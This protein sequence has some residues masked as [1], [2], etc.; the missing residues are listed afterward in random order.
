[1]VEPE[2][3]VEPTPKSA[4]AKKFATKK[5]AAKP[6]RTAYPSTVSKSASSSAPPTAKKAD[7]SKPSAPISHRGKE[8]SVSKEKPPNEGGVREVG[9]GTSSATLPVESRAH[10]SASSAGL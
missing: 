6:K 3:P 10:S 7:K 8:P 4:R 2:D 1:M 9:A 5:A